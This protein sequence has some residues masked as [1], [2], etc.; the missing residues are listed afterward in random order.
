MGSP[1][2]GDP[3]TLAT[4]ADFVARFPELSKGFNETVI[5]DTLVEATDHIEGMCSR[6]LAPFTNHLYQDRIFGIDPSEY[7]SATP[8]VPLPWG[9]TLGMSYASALGDGQLARHFWLDQFA[10]FHPELWTYNIHSITIELTYGNTMDIDFRNGGIVGPAITDGH[11]WLRLGTFVPI[12]SRVDVSYDGGYTLGTPPALKRA[13]LY[14]AAKF[15]LIDAEPQ[16][17]S[18]MNLDELDAQLV[19]IM[20]SWAR[21]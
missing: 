1:V 5:A 21:G 18:G 4:M 13:C 15:L 12:G 16:F 3:V 8:N 19:S 17:R 14:Q 9:G 7:G 6:R 2:A 10:P 11:C 20:A